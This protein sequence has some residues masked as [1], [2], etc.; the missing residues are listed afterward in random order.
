MLNQELIFKNKKDFEPI[1]RQ[2]IGGIKR[3]Q[4]DKSQPID[5]QE[6]EDIAQQALIN[7]ARTR[8]ERNIENF[9]AYAF[10][11]AKNLYT[12]LLDKKIKRSL[13]TVEM[14]DNDED[15]KEKNSLT[16]DKNESQIRKLDSMPIFKTCINKLTR[17]QYEVLYFQ[18]SGGDEEKRHVMKQKDLSKTMGIPLGTLKP[19]L[20]RA[21]KA[22]GECIKKQKMAAEGAT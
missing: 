3:L 17:K 5:H 8:A 1:F 6:A 14:K 15:G 16:Y 9:R 21:K 19:L 4:F 2:L 10:K 20:M 7:L 13:K 18:I 12:N 11:T 22:L